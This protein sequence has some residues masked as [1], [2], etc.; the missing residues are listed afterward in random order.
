MKESHPTGKDEALHKLL[1]TW[2]SDAQLPPRFQEA[3]WQRIE[4]ANK[5]VKAPL[6]QRVF[7][8]IEASFARPAFA[9][10]YV[11]ALLAAGIGTGY[12]QAEGRSAE[13]KSNLRTRYVQSVDPYQMPR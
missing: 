7:A 3:V 11:A 13:V 6:W 4:R 5:D 8:S 12:W 1:C 2:K 10:A 9:T